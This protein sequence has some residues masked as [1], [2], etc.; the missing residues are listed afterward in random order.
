MAVMIKGRSGDDDGRPARLE[1]AVPCPSP[2]T[3]SEPITSTIADLD[4]EIGNMKQEMANVEDQLQGLF[5]RY[6]QLEAATRAA[7]TR[8]NALTPFCRLPLDVLEH[9][10]RIMIRD[11]NPVFELPLAE[12]FGSQA[13]PPL[14]TGCMPM[15]Q[16]CTHMRAL[17]LAS[18][19]LWSYVDV[20]HSKPWITICRERAGPLPLFISCY[21]EFPL[22]IT[23][24]IALMNQAREIYF[25]PP[26]YPHEF[27][28][29]N[30]LR[31]NAITSSIISFTL[32]NTIIDDDSFLVRVRFL[33]HM[34]QSLTR[35]VL[36]AVFIPTLTS[37][38]QLVELGLKGVLF[39]EAH[40]LRMLVNGAPS[41][42]DVHLHDVWVEEDGAS[43][44]P[45]HPSLE[46]LRIEG[47]LPRVGGLFCVLPT[48]ARN[49]VL[50]IL[51]RDSN[52]RRLEHVDD[53]ERETF[54]R[55]ADT[56]ILAHASNDLVVHLRFAGDYIM[57]FSNSSTATDERHV[58]YANQS[59][60]LA[61]L[62]PVCSMIHT[63][64][65]H[66]NVPAV[67]FSGSEQQILLQLSNLRHLI[68]ELDAA[69]VPTA[70]IIDGLRLRVAA[71][72]TLSTLQIILDETRKDPV[73]DVPALREALASE[74][75]VAEL[76]ENGTVVWQRHSLSEA[77]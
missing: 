33:S 44:Y 2:P 12:A 59:R 40:G 22:V 10:L 76:H 62:H 32:L 37:M 46:S 39:D 18:P 77:T 30:A 73:I 24:A 4:R 16:I 26:V 14:G 27:S 15:L 8:R 43:N 5:T 75:L 55:A 3:M 61:G 42:R 25:C 1:V 6:E 71:G 52:A 13:R 41:L 36:Q 66:H 50:H 57:S 17:A 68:L 72:L 49:L 35:L 29:T 31:G 53:L 56:V 64:H 60:T 9:L 20:N 63:L 7:A 45:A 51:N 28:D 19:Y 21:S 70:D 23:D 48:P 65:V 38:P 47:S 67:L 69:N 54:R 58:S 34:A 11:W 74:D